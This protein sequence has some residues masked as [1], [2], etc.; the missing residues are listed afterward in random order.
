MAVR[1]YI[2]ARYVAKIYENSQDP[3]SSEWE[4]NVTWEPLVI[5]TYQNGSYMS[6]KPIPGNIGNPPRKSSVLDTDRIL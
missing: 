5:V 3:T 4:P 6:K 2:G 1:Q